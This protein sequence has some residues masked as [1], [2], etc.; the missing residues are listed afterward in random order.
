MESS[1]LVHY[2]V[3]GEKGS[4]NIVYD[5]LSPARNKKDYSAYVNHAMSILRQSHESLSENQKSSNSFGSWYSLPL[6]NLTIIILTDTLMADENAM[7]MMKSMSGKIFSTFP[8]LP[9]NPSTQIN[10]S[11]ME[12]IVRSLSQTYGKTDDK[13]YRAK[14]TISTTTNVM[15]NNIGSM[16]ENSSKLEDMESQSSDMRNAA[17]MFSKSGRLLE[18]KMKRRNRLLM[19]AVGVIALFFIILLIFYFF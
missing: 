6:D 8:D 17:H 9:L 11:E 7:Q 3:I 4:K 15:R 5:Y 14:Q 1:S 16:M 13:I 12:N 18:E 2:V 10:R 19:L